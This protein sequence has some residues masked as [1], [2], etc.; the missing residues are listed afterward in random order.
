MNVWNNEVLNKK[1]ENG[2][3]YAKKHFDRTVLTEKYILLIE[4]HLNR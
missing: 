4:K 3:R 2:Y 1:G